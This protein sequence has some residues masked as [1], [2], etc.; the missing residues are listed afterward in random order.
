MSKY[1]KVVRV[2][3][4]D[5]LTVMT[6]KYFSDWMK[7]NSYELFDDFTIRT[8][9][10]GDEIVG[11]VKVEGKKDYHFKSVHGQF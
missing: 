1:F 7:E 5:R 10:K 11:Q 4:P 2:K 6:S 9:R 3:F 8:N